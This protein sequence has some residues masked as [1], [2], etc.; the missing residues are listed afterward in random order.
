VAQVLEYLPAGGVGQREK[1][2]L[3]SHD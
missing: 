3:V 1:C 2:C